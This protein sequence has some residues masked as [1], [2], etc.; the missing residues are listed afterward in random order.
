MGHFRLIHSYLNP[1]PM[2]SN[3]LALTLSILVYSAAPLH[4]DIYQWIGTTDSVWGTATNWGTGTG[5]TAG[6][7]PTGTTTLHR[8]NVNNNAANPLIYDASLGTT[9]YA[10]TA[11]G[12]RGLVIG[13]GA[14]GAGAM[15]ITGGTF[16]TFGSTAEDIIGN[17]T[18]AATSSLTIAGGNFIGNSVGFI[19]GFG[20]ANQTTSLNI[21]S[22]SA[23]FSALTLN[24]AATGSATVNLDGGTLTANQIKRNGTGTGTMNFNG[25]TLVAGAASTTFLQGLSA[26]NV[27]SGGA[28]IDT[29]SFNITVAQPL[30][31]G[32]GGGGLTKTGTATLTL[33]GANTYTGTTTISAGT[34]QIGAGATAGTFG[35]GSVT[36]NAALAFN[37]SDNISVSNAISGTGSLTK[38]AAGTLT[39]GSSNS[40][41]GATTISVGAIV[42]N[43][44]TG[45]LGDTT[46]G[47]T[48][49]N[50]ATLALTGGVNYAA[51][52][53][54]TITGPGATGAAYFFVGSA[55][56]RGAIQSISG[57]NTWNGNISISGANTRIGV[58]DGATLTLTG[59]ITESVAGTVLNIRGGNT[60]G[61][62][63]TISGT[64]NSWTGSTDVFSGGGAIKLG[65]DNALPAASLLR[66]GTTGIAGNTIFDMNGKNQ[67][68]AGLSQVGGTAAIVTNNGSAASTFTLSPSASQTFDGKI[69]DGTNPLAITKT[70][71]SVQI[72]TGANAYSGMTNIINGTLLANN[73]TGSATGTS[74]ILVGGGA[75][76]GGTGSV[77]GTVTTSTGSFLSPGVSIESLTV[78]SALGNG[79]LRVEYD[80]AAGSPIDLLAV[81]GTFSIAT[82]SLDF[83]PLGS[84]L[85]APAYVF[86]SYGTL[87][88]A[89]FA[90]TSNVPSGYELDYNYSGGNQI[91]LVAVPEPAGLFGLGLAVSGLLMRRRRD[92]V[93]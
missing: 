90:S 71:S 3:R 33:A 32:T 83:Q 62:D 43:A 57:N 72:F 88:G 6:P 46:A 42:V 9:V 66:V 41:S 30:L 40:Y 16:S 29:G 91:A 31:D 48:V 1:P 58:Q 38:L 70:G 44:N 68:S 60:A 20:S 49:A 39:L 27:K 10:N 56:Q 82:M 65:T 19:L 37:R 80:G 45:V 34:L 61:S 28:N 87:D 50:N 5:L 69:Q 7:G 24:N 53:S 35:T 67:T 81:T 54:L 63:V 59:N 76:F 18:T 52:E 21:S 15:S 23:T 79:T 92:D 11:V 78:G 25:G 8:L 2:K 86:A 13:S 55:V 26:A 47:T 73:T 75:T 14:L 36:N 77:T 89:A 12:S 84:P 22:G 51:G 17:A 4:A 74:S 64:A 93:K 85:T